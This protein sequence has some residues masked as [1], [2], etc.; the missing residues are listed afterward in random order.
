M[1]G[2]HPLLMCAILVGFGGC[3]GYRLGPSNGMAAGS[4]SIQ[5]APFLNETIEPRLSD[6]VVTS[7]RRLLQ[8]DG[9]FTLNTQGDGDV[10]LKGVITK[11]DR[12]ALSFEPRDI[13]TVRDYN[14][15]ITAKVTAVDR[16]SGKTVLDREVK[17][18]TTVRT[19]ANQPS[20]ELQAVSLLADDL[21]RNLTSLLVDGTW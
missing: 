14:V 17:G 16:I 2:L 15:V 9:T 11:Y 6:A 10:V 18:R 8:Q 13:L 19:G 5:V 7:I 4:R 21:A 3:A 20:A 12:T 1:R